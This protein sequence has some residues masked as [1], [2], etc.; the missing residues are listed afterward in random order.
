MW[1]FAAR[2][3]VFTPH[4]QP[5]RAPAPAGLGSEQMNLSIALSRAVAPRLWAIVQHYDSNE[6]RYTVTVSIWVRW[7]LLLA[8]LVESTYR[9]E[10]GAL[11]HVLNT[12]YVLAMMSAN[13]FLLWRIRSTG[14]VDTRWLLAVSAMDVACISFSVAMSGGFESR[15][16]P[17]YYCSAAVFAWLFASPFLVLSWTTLL[18]AIYVALCLLLRDGVDFG[19]QEEKVLFYR[20]LG[21]Y[22]VA[23]WVNL[24]ARFE[25]T[26]RTRAM[27]REG[28]M[29]R[30][31]IEMSQSIHDTTAQSAYMIGLGL[32][33]A[34]DMAG[35]SNPR[36]TAKLQAVSDLARTTMW[37]LRRPIDGGEL[38]SG[39]GLGE[40]LASHVDTFT[41]IT[42]IEAEFVQRGEEPELSPI[43]RSLLFSIAHN[44]L[45][46]AFRHSAAG[47]VTVSLDFSREALRLSV[48]D[49]GVG[50][51]DD[52]DRRGHGFRNMGADARRLGG[53]LEARSDDQG[54]TVTCLAPCP[55]KLR[56]AHND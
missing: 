44:A 37:E 36:L 33:Q 45:T 43:A 46:N 26:L 29:A 53:A 11:S 35:G 10:Y 8:C 51:P 42:S 4:R 2:V 16:F 27:E 28:E 20:L 30:Q 19:H 5:S 17:L 34:V 31:R 24:V 21:L 50:L 54:T 23:V 48:S 38:F 52:Y 13:G 15:Y 14:R 18:A 49:N 32:E 22:W 6:L 25:R 47:K 1:T 56:R 55:D 39:A 41:V 9:I 7:A 12:L 40:V 3:M